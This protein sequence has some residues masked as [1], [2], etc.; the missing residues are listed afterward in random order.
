M[1]LLLLGCCLF[2]YSDEI[3]QLLEPLQEFNHNYYNKYG[4]VAK[5][6]GLYIDMLKKIG[7]SNIVSIRKHGKPSSYI[8][9]SSYN[10]V[11]L[12]GRYVVGFDVTG[13]EN[14]YVYINIHQSQCSLAIRS[15]GEH[16]PIHCKNEGCYHP[17]H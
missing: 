12:G 13:E 10:C 14:I 15:N 4:K 16:S 3:K 6:E 7:C 5:N 11:Y 2:N 1:P 8:Y 17:S 9:D